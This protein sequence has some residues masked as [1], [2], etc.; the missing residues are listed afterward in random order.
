M[1]VLEVLRKPPKNTLVMVA[2]VPS[3]IETEPLNASLE[4]FN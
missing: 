4:H 2:S 3:M 1:E